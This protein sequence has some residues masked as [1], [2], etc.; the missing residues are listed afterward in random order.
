MESL[1]VEAARRDTKRQEQGYVEVEAHHQSARD[2]PQHTGF[3]AS[4]FKG[5]INP[6]A[7]AMPSSN[8]KADFSKIVKNEGADK[9]PKACKKPEST[10]VGAPHDDD[11]SEWVDVEK[12]LDFEWESVT[13]KINRMPSHPRVDGGNSQI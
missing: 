2:I 5:F 12:D 9:M 11:S 6:L 7:L 10:Q 3:Y 1:E 8:T 4:L 13:A